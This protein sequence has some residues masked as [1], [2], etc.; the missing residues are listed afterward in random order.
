M[1]THL[2]VS[3]P[4]FFFR[5]CNLLS[6]DGGGAITHH[7]VWVIKLYNTRLLHSLHL[8]SN[9]M[10]QVC[11]CWLVGGCFSF[12]T[13]QN[14]TWVIALSCPSLH[15][16]KPSSNTICRSLSQ[17]CPS[18][19][20]MKW[21]T[22]VWLNSIS[23]NVSIFELMRYTFWS[24]LTSPTQ[25]HLTHSISHLITWCPLRSIQCEPIPASEVSPSSHFTQ[26]Q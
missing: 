15:P 19:G 7:N 13:P 10:I 18:G 21:Y 12:N 8:V 22:V 4:L 16:N 11:L 26:G 17:I 6:A 3:E 25:Y 1:E 14:Q 23:R 5:V 24:P 2:F 20:Q 9:R